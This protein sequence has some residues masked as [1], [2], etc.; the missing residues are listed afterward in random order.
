MTNVEWSSPVEA[1]AEALWLSVTAPTDRKSLA[2]LELAE[3]LAAGLSELEV[4]RAK[5]L[6]EARI[7]A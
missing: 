7:N 1:L 4:A 3:R 5:A 2:A 6:A